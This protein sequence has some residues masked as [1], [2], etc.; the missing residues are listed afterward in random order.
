MCLGCGDYCFAE[1]YIERISL[2][3]DFEF[4]IYHMPTYMKGRNS[5][6]SCKQK[7]LPGEREE[8]GKLKLALSEA[9]A[10]GLGLEVRDMC[11]FG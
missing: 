9:E 8:R 7:V 5:R 4:A 3:G 1:S 6:A 11:A 10:P 2:Q